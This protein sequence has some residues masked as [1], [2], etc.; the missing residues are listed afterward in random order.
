[1]SAVYFLFH[2][3]KYGDPNFIF[4]LVDCCGSV[5]RMCPTVC[6]PMDYSAAHQTS[7][8]FTISQSLLKLISIVLVIPSN[9]LFLCCL[10]L[11]LPSVFPSIRIFSNESDLCIKWS[12]YW[13]FS[14][15]ISLSNGYSRLIFFTIDG[16]ALLAVQGTLFKS[17]TQHHTLK[18]EK[19]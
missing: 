1:M 17:L 11:L 5:S 16:F 6:D 10:L 15:S 12:K 18:H 2:S 9:H 19:Y 3:A 14:F 7:L 4:S 13:N 8:S